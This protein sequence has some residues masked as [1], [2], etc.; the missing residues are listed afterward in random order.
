LDDGILTS[1]T[2]D[3]LHTV[4]NPKTDAAWHLHHA[5]THLTT[6]THFIL[7]SSV[8][9]TY[10]TAGQGSYA[11]GNAFLDALAQHR[12]AQGLPATSL[13]WGLWDDEN[14]TMSGALTDADRSRLARTGIAALAPS[15]GLELFDDALTMDAPVLLPMA[16]DTAALRASGAEVPA[17]LRGLVRTPA[18]RSAQDSA[19]VSGNSLTERLAGLDAAE[20]QQLLLELVR[21]EVAAA[22]D[23]AGADA[24]DERRGFKE[25]GIDSLTAVELR[26]RLNKATG[27]RLPATLVFDHPTPDAVA[28]LLRTELGGTAAVA[29][30]T[31]PVVDVR[32]DDDPVVIVG[33]SA[34]FP[35]GVRSP[36][37]LWHLVATGGDAIS[38]FPADRGWDLE[39]LYD[40]DPETA[41]TSY[42]RE[43][44]FLHDAAQFDAEFF[45]ISP[46]EALAMDPQQ[47]LLLEASW[48]AF[49]QAGIDPA[50][51]RGSR[52]GVYA[53]VMYHDYASRLPSL[54]GDL[55]GYLGTGN[56][57]SVNSGRISYTFGLEGPA[58]TVD[59]ACSSSL[60]ALHLAAQALRQGE[61]SLA[62]VGG[63]T[64]MSSPGTFVEFSRQRGLAPDGRCKP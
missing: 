22:L 20:Q 32:T 43:G 64:V 26:N 41:G 31:G 15:R 6:L 37:E 56:T 3:R 28:E 27:L 59:T 58:V 33:M 9:G 57:G 36:E 46:R 2:P 52:T 42:A 62:V 10:G 60:V 45:G 44:G 47:R 13:A 23:Y 29:S 5:T 35:G 39:A 19:G 8:A 11:A 50:R 53:G 21:T 4:L 54:P 51:L 49:E 16:L 24:V 7:F 38:G 25:L 34:R 17:I 1:L 55:E 30:V 61:C 18:R 14:S 48:E 40:P 63:V 12:H